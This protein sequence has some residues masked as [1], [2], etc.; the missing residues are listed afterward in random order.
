MEERYWWIG[1]NCV[2]GVGSITSKRLIEAFGTPKH[3]FSASQGELRSVDGVGGEL[4]RRIATF[5]VEEVLEREV[6][7]VERAGITLCTLHDEDYPP[8]LVTLYDPPPVLYV[9]GA[10]MASDQLAIAVVGSRR[11]TAY[12]RSVA[13]RL[14]GELASLG[15]TVV[16]GLA[17][18]IDGLV[19]QAALS[20]GGRT[21]AVYGSGIDLVFPAEHRELADAIAERGALISEFPMGVPPV[22]HNFPRRNR[23]IAGLALGTV[24]VEA[25]AKSGSLITARCAMEQGREVFAVPGQVITGKS[26]G[27]HRLIKQGAVKLDGKKVVEVSYRARITSV[28]VGGPGDRLFNCRMKLTSGALVGTAVHRSY[29]PTI[30]QQAREDV[31]QSTTWTEADEAAHM[32]DIQKR[33]KALLQLIIDG[34]RLRADSDRHGARTPAFVH[35]LVFVSAA[36]LVMQLERA[37]QR[38]QFDHFMRRSLLGPSILI[39]DE[40]G[41]L[42]LQG[43]QANLF[44]QVIAK[45]YEHGSII[46]TS[47]LSFGEWDSTFA[48]NS[49][50]T[51]AMLDR[52]LHHAH[53]VQIKGDSYRLKDK[54]K[55]GVLT[56]ASHDSPG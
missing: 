18:G 14:A 48:G 38:G 36:D 2:P 17:R 42:P 4:A 31:F 33:E 46:L 49:A 12:G 29:Y 19:H 39:I 43:N 55:A 47:N 21:L 23:I 41:Y 24:V 11:P 10:L 34:T 27:A 26:R 3:V 35:N 16:S 51:A 28:P 52:L 9:R 20:A 40:V 6:A 30:S 53:V 15:F 45:R 8:Q 54:R 22:A 56:L 25:A 32:K 7:A 44:F 37:Q 1:L 13:E 5:P 50:L